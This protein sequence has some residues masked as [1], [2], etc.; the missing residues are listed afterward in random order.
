[1]DRASAPAP[2]SL[3]ERAAAVNAVYS[4]SG[5]TESVRNSVGCHPAAASHLFKH[6]VGARGLAHALR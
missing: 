3:P 1:M 4:A 2:E 6:L 5:P